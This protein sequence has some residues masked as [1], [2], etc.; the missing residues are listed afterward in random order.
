M[1]SD[2]DMDR[3][4]LRWP[5]RLSH[6]ASTRMY[7]PEDSASAQIIHRCLDTISSVLQHDPRPGLGQEIAK[8][9]PPHRH[10]LS[11]TSGLT[12]VT[13][14]SE[15]ES[16]LLH[17]PDDG[18][19]RA[20]REMQS[21]LTALL[22]EVTALNKELDSRR[23]E[24]GEIYE[25]LEG[26]CRG[27]TRTIAELEGEVAELQADLVE[28]AVEL[29]GM[30]GT[31]HG[32]QCYIDALRE[33]RRVTRVQ[34]LD[35][36]ARQKGSRRNG[37]RKEEELGDPDDGLVLEGIAAWMRGWRDVEEGFQVR[38]RARRLKREWRQGRWR[39]GE[40]ISY[41]TSSVV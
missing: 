2:S 27:L 19:P 37:S 3:D 9:R 10:S 41:K 23:R 15:V 29:E 21:Q 40:G 18:E 38:A 32:L 34:R 20:N 28:D 4:S 1:S 26:R 36:R 12:A 6:L 13:P 22:R 11:L 35:H 30:Q 5:A 24:A 14:E 33:E 8:Y 39:G 17:V 31:V 16:P 7:F 25:L